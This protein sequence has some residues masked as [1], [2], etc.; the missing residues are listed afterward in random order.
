MYKTNNLYYYQ[1][2]FKLVIKD[3]HCIH[4]NRKELQKLI[5]HVYD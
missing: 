1:V 2:N 5:F 4:Q 3:I